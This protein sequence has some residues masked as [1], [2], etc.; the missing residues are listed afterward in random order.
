MPGSIS[1]PAEGVR[2]G[3]AWTTLDGSLSRAVLKCT[4]CNHLAWHDWH[5]PYC[6]AQPSNMPSPDYPWPSAGKHLHRANPDAGCPY[7]APAE[8]APAL[9]AASV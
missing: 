7:P 6:S 9:A 4:G 2:N 1:E 5:Y 8:P 3:P